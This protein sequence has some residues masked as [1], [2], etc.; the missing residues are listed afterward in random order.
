[1][2]FG[3]ETRALREKASKGLHRGVVEAGPRLH[4]PHDP[5]TITFSG[6]STALH[7]RPLPGNAPAAGRA[8]ATAPWMQHVPRSASEAA[9]AAAPAADASAR[10]DATAPN[11]QLNTDARPSSSS[12][13]HNVVLPTIGS[14]VSMD[15]STIGD[16]P[17]AEMMVERPVVVPPAPDTAGAAPGHNIDPPSSATG[18]W[19]PDVAIERERVRDEKRALEQRRS[20]KGLPP[21]FVKL[22]KGAPG[23]RHNSASAPAL[24]N[25]QQIVP[26]PQFFE[27]MSHEE[28]LRRRRQSSAPAYAPFAMSLEV[29]E[30]FGISGRV[31]MQEKERLHDYLAPPE[32]SPS[33]LNDVGATDSPPL[34]ESRCAWA[35]GVAEKAQRLKWRQPGLATLVGEASL[36]EGVRGNAA[37][38]GALDP[39]DAA[40]LAA[41]VP[42]ASDVG[43][44]GG[45]LSSMQLAERQASFPGTTPVGASPVNAGLSNSRATMIT[46]STGHMEYGEKPELGHVVGASPSGASQ[47][48]A[49][50][51]VFESQQFAVD[52]AG[53]SDGLMQTVPDIR[54]IFIP[55]ASPGCPVEACLWSTEEKRAYCVACWPLLP[56]HEDLGVFVNPA[57]MARAGV[58]AYPAPG[59]ENRSA[60][61]ARPASSASDRMSREGGSRGGT[62][63][64]SKSRQ[65][66]PGGGMMAA[67]STSSI[68]LSKA[69]SVPSSAKPLIEQLSMTGP[70]GPAPEAAPFMVECHEIAPHSRRYFESVRR[71]FTP[72]QPLFEDLK[73]GEDEAIMREFTGTKQ[74]TVHPATKRAQARMKKKEKAMKRAL[75]QKQKADKAAAQ[76]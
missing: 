18:R 65:A 4:E 10:M 66:T 33:H 73:L 35:R 31:G 51:S 58:V 14:P 3:E 75:L 9:E 5:A 20:A 39:Y 52:G 70:T 62:P 68:A 19:T 69:Y 21:A 74:F 71:G 47:Q 27:K 59:M 38:A 60:N 57:V 24:F 72:Q 17:G 56:F 7:R 22:R 34:R 50:G 44:L 8:S 48:Q 37:G 23:A 63:K 42:N 1:M 11:I 6:S 40:S 13:M 46:G 54:D 32:S 49:P 76:K 55:C 16:G 28:H 43:A 41:V 15:S 26:P 61:L 53:A 25:V 67:S 45:S 2:G 30:R 36:F 12:G 64:S 29:R